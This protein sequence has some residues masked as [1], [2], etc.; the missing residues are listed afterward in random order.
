MWHTKN[1]ND[2]IKELKSNNTTGLKSNEITER[3]KTYGKNE[4]NSKKKENIII[5]FFKQ[6]NDF[7]VIILIISAIISA[8]TAYVEK[9]NDYIDSIIIIA[10]VIFN[11]LM[12]LIQEAKAEKSIEALK[13]MFVPSSKV[14]R[15]GKLI[16][17]A[18]EQI[19]PGDIIELEAGSLVP[20]DCRIISSFNLQ[21]DESTLTGETVPVIKDALK[22]LPTSTPI[23]DTVN[24]AFASTI[25]TNGRGTAIV[26]DTGMNT[27][28]GKIAHMI[29]DSKDNMTPLQKRLAK[30]GKTLGVCAIIICIIIFIIGFLKDIPILEMFTTSVGL[31][32]ASIPEGL[33]AIVT[34]LLSI[35]VTRM[36]KKN[37]IIRKL[38]AVETLG[39]ST[40]ICSDKTGTLTQNKM[41]VTEF[42]SKDDRLFQ[43]ATMCT[44]C[45]VI[46]NRVSGDPSEVAIVEHALT[47]LH[48]KDLLYKKYP[49]I[50]EIPFDSKRKLMT[51][52]H[53]EA[54]GYLI[55]TKGAPDILI[56]K[57]T[58]LLNNGNQIKMDTRIQ[59]EFLSQNDL[60]ANKALRVLAVAISHRKELGYIN[61]KNIEQDLTLV[62]LIGMID[63]P[64]Q[65]VKDAISACRKAGIKTVMITGDHIITAKA[66]AKELG[67]LKANEI[68]ITGK[69]LDELNE[70]DFQKNI[71]KYSVFA[72]VSP[73]HKVKI[74]KAFQKKGAIVAMTGD[75][76]NDAPALKNANI[77][78]AMGKTGTDVAK[79]ASD[80]ILTDDNFV[81][82]T[83]A[84]KE[85][86]HIYDN[87]KKAVHFLISTNV[88]EIIT[89]FFALI[90]GF[91]SPLLAIHLLWINLVTDSFPAI[92]LGMEKA[93][94]DI[95]E[96]PPI[97][98]KKGFFAN[99]LWK[100]ILFEGFMIGSLTL[101]VFNIG[102]KKFDL[103]VARTMAFVSL[104]LI[105]LVHSLNIKSNYS[106]LKSGM[107][108]NL[109]LIGAFILGVLLQVVVVTIPSI[110]SIFNCTILLPEQWKIVLIFSIMPIPIIEIQK[111]FDDFIYKNKF[112][113]A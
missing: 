72:R 13:A 6:F 69:E 98:P 48:N 90:L 70:T 57:C 60:M 42:Y 112:P 20:A 104:S 76:V 87:I 67:I 31:A 17:I 25:V 36:A 62:G 106:I 110:A 75:G 26:T 40:V 2:V 52:I 81:T 15:D 84:V 66:I 107:R 22:I 10:I 29:N 38:P 105:E 71:M 74:V 85:G 94:K 30:V 28:V 11:A 73:E 103:E 1:S 41:N 102:I 92:G 101:I 79:S 18:S 39:S 45:S 63:P 97:N 47:K 93:E 34:I 61:E 49:R 96:H 16:S 109:Y 99:D 12:G 55:I 24:M 14:K 91:D 58:Y 43:Y 27:K 77:G 83:E 50:G 80:M 82:I 32:V 88:G 23:G 111:F 4:I 7:M 9:T 65:G 59:K 33:P 100:K 44:D 56:S 19:V 54:N 113:P 46:S 21:I 89:I 8:L 68:A 78:I 35:G 53:K 5:K 3:L 51:T 64:R 95:M 86:R 37:A 108:F